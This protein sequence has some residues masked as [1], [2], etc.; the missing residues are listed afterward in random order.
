M[1]VSMRTE[2]NRVHRITTRMVKTKTRYLITKIDQDLSP[3]L[4]RLFKILG[5]RY[6]PNE[7]RVVEEHVE[8]VEPTKPPDL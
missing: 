7:T 2:L 4:E 1:P 5:L 6:N 3:F 8:E